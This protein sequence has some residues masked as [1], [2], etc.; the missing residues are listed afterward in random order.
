MAVVA[1]LAA[2][3]AM[4]TLIMRIAVGRIAERAGGTNRLYRAPRPTPQNQQVVRTSP[5]L[6]YAVCAL[7]LSRGAVRLTMGGA[8]DYASLAVYDANTDNVFTVNDR[9]LP[10]DGITVVVAGTDARAAAE[11]GEPVVRLRGPRGLA[12]IRRLAPTDSAFAR[13]ERERSE[14]RC[15][16]ISGGQPASFAG[17]WQPSGSSADPTPQTGARGMPRTPNYGFEKRRR[18]QER[19]EKKEAKARRR[20]EQRAAGE[21][22]GEGGENDAA[23]QQLE[24]PSDEG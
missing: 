14:D 10:P 17:H 24:S 4:P 16:N 11:P 6:A 3:T 21:V 7:D 23:D 12:L 22:E 13:V 2:I 20:A 5:D 19:Q 18:E 8:S 1:H 15:A 9:Q